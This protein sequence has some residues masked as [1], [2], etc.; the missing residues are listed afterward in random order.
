MPMKS[1]KLAVFL[2]LVL[3]GCVQNRGPSDVSQGKQ[4]TSGNADYDEFFGEVYQTQV[5]LGAAP[6]REREIRQHLSQAL[7][8]D[9]ESRAEEI[10]EAL[11]KRVGH[12][13]KTAALKLTLSGMEEDGTPSFVLTTTGTVTDPKDKA[14][15]EAVAQA[16]KDAATLL[17]DARRAAAT[18]EHLRKEAPTLEPGIDQKFGAAGPGKK[19]DVSRNLGDAERMIPLMASRATDIEERTSGLLRKLEKALGEPPA[20]EGGTKPAKGEA[21]VPKKGKEK[22]KAAHGEPKGGGHAEPKPGHAPKH[23]APKSEASSDET[24]APKKP[25]PKP[26]PPPSD[27]FEP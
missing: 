21:E 12:I 7:D 5:S 10:A 22:P 2:S 8:I 3:A 15:V 1:T 16:G 20:E 14:T 18:T 9:P 25:P 19:D 11:G 17:A 26:A 23:A 24:E 6:N 13:G 27:D 4:F